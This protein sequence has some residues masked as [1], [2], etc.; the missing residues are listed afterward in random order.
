[1]PEP[2]KCESESLSLE[3]A[4]VEPGLYQVN[5]PQGFFSGFGS[6]M[7]DIWQF[8]ELL[9]NLTR[10]ELKVRYRDSILGFLW[11]IQ[12]PIMQLLIY[13]LVVGQFL[14]G[15]SV[16]YLGIFMFCGLAVWT[17]F[18][19]SLTAS[20]ASVV[21]N[22]G[23]IKKVYFPRELIPL[24]AV[25]ASTINFGIQFAVL[26]CATIVAC[27]ISGV[28]PDI[29]LIGLPVLGFVTLIIFVTA[30]G[31]ILSALNVYFR[32]IQHL[33]TVIAMLWFWM[34]PVLY[35]A[36]QVATTVP[37]V[38]Y[39]AYLLNPITP[40]VISFQKFFWPQGA[41]SAFDFDDHLGVRLLGSFAFSVV[42]LWLAHRVFARL[43]GNFAQEL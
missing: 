2:A 4:T 11:G 6:S 31:M 40:V 35:S 8:R 34:T 32:D 28:W 10:Q 19:E 27:C 41:G 14:A 3:L 25:G 7:R 1:M 43:Q 9:G 30:L 36:H 33:V 39:Q 15:G 21:A 42:L 17:L 5:A 23:L 20:T 18:G 26:I 22:G 38:V 16:P 24:A 37:R 13:W 12:L 29:G